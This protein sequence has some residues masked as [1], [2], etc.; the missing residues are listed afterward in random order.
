MSFD[1]DKEVKNRYQVSTTAMSLKDAYNNG[2]SQPST[3]GSG[4]YALYIDK[5]LK[6]IGKAVY[7]KGI[8][9]RM[10]QYYRLTK[11]GCNEINDIIKDLVEVHFFMLDE[12]KCWLEERRLQVIATDSGEQLFWENKTRN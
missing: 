5:E 1:F 4:I 7:D 10:S 11:E 3:T 2:Q 6:K 12:K 9:T 8:F